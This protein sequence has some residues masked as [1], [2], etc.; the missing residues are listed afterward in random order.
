MVSE[1]QMT[2][3]ITL[4][5]EKEKLKRNHGLNKRMLGYNL[6]CFTVIASSD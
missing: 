3:L 6:R 4:K 5:K 1:C 2:D